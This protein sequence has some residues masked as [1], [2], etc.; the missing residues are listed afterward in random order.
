[1]GY[2]CSRSIW[3]TNVSSRGS[4]RAVG[5]ELGHHFLGQASAPFLWQIKEFLASHH[6]PSTKK[7]QQRLVVTT[8]LQETTFPP[9]NSP[10]FGPSVGSPS[11]TNIMHN[12]PCIT[13]SMTPLHIPMDP[14]FASQ[15]QGVHFLSPIKPAPH[16]ITFFY[17][18]MLYWGCNCS[19]ATLEQL[20]L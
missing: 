6:P 1:M 20:P 3:W 7:P 2:H 10:G 12:A 9:Q 13:Q 19:G 5:W 16:F 8:E 15:G 11:L 18:S 14:P 4:V 17:C